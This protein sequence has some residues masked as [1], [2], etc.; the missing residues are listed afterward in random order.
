MNLPPDPAR[1]GFTLFEVLVALAVISLMT[2]VVLA[3]RPTP[4]PALRL[5]AAASALIEDATRA[6]HR[7]VTTATDQVWTPDALSCDGAEVRITFYADGSADTSDICL[8]EE[9][10]QM[11][12][13]I[14]VLAGRLAEVAS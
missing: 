3:A 1:A 2:A 13:E 9:E 14:N 7:A 11:R 8:S 10:R 12:L 5:N 4:S 6:R